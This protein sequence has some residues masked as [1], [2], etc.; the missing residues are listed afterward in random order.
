MTTATNLAA[1][2]QANPRQANPGGWGWVAI[3]LGVAAVGAVA[4]RGALRRGTKRAANCPPKVLPVPYEWGYSADHPDALTEQQLRTMKAGDLATAILSPENR[5]LKGD[6]V[7]GQDL[8]YP[9]Y[10]VPVKLRRLDGDIDFV[11]DCR[12]DILVPGGENLIFLGI[13][14]HFFSGPGHDDPAW[15]QGY[16]FDPAKVPPGK[17]FFLQPPK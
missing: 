16:L 4:L 9:S 2:R 17:Q 3:T 12:M 11:T 7:P 1:Y 6:P 10:T 14:P 8:K 15:L 13:G 5:D